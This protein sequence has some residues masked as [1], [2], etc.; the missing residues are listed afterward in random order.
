LNN[1][2]VLVRGQK[3]GAIGPAGPQGPRGLAGPAVK[4]VSTCAESPGLGTPTCACQ[5]TTITR[6]S[7]P[8]T[9]TSETGQC[10]AAAGGCC[11]VCAP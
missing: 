4:T 10:N 1:G 8:C 7:G 3:I 11:A 5:A 2:D 9:V 6:S